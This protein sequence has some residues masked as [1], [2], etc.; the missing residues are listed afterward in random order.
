MRLSSGFAPGL[1]YRQ[2]TKRRSVAVVAEDFARGGAVLK[3]FKAGE[4]RHCWRVSEGVT[5]RLTY[6]NQ[7]IEDFRSHT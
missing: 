3:G 4:G 6:E 2:A 5:G 7:G 1:G